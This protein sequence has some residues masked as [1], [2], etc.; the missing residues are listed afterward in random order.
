MVFFQIKGS[1]VISFNI[2]TINHIFVYNSF[3]IL[4]VHITMFYNLFYL[5][6]FFWGTGFKAFLL[7]LKGF[8]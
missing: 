5:A 3:R 2:S 4:K 6:D 1:A 8:H 7:D